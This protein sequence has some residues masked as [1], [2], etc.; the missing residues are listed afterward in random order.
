MKLFEMVNRAASNLGVVEKGIGPLIGD[1]VLF[2]SMRSILASQGTKVT[3]PYSQSVWV[4]AALNAITSN[5]S[6]VPFLLKKDAGD[7]EPGK[8]E[9]GPLYEVMMKPNPLMILKT[10]IQA[11]FTYMGLRGEAIWILEREN[12][13]QI[14]Q[15]IWCFDPMRFSPSINKETGLIDLYCNVPGLN[16]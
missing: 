10:L 4:Y 8:I 5:L 2:R 9:E 15:A 6:R 3:S 16:I 11:T 14:P 12:I 13:S 1:Q 7:L